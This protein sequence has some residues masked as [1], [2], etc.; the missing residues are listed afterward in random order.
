MKFYGL[1]IYESGS[2]DDVA[3]YFESDTPFGAISK[4]DLIN[5]VD[6]EGE[7]VKRILRVVG[8]EH[9]VW[10]SKSEGIKHKTCVFT[11]AEENNRDAR[12]K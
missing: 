3:A 12:M 5:P 1:E 10:E 6:S 8:I 9:I 4:G 11:A 2:A 7:A